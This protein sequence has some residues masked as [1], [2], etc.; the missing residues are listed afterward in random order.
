MNL[1]QRCAG[2]IVGTFAVV[3]ADEN[4]DYLG[5]TTLGINSTRTKPTQRVFGKG[6]L[7]PVRC[8]TTAC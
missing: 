4:L 6:F 8:I 2:V 5:L 3:G 1:A 7:E